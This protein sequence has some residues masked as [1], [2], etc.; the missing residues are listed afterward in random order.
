MAKTTKSNDNIEIVVS[1]Y[2]PTKIIKNIYIK[3]NKQEHFRKEVDLER[4]DAQ[5]L[6]EQLKDIFEPTP[7]E[8]KKGAQSE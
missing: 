7:A 5:C 4:G 8:A 6:Y 2:W 3:N 1:T